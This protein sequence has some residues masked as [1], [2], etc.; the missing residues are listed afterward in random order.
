MPRYSA[1]SVGALLAVFASGAA[2]AQIENHAHHELHS[3]PVEDG[4]AV[5][6]DLG[7]T[8]DVWANFGGVKDGT[9]YLDNLDLIVGA[10]LEKLIGWR[11]ATASAYVLYNNGKSFG[12]LTGDALA[13]SNIE[14]GVQAVRLYEAWIE[15][16]IVSAATVKVGLYDL[17]SEFDSLE[18]A[19]LF[20]GSAHGIGMD[21]AQTGENGPSIFPSTSLA[22]RV[23]F[24]VQDNLVIR[25]AVLD[26]VPGNPDHPKRTAIRL[27]NGEGV[28]L[29]GEIDYGN[30]DARL[31]AGAWG[32]SEA[33]PD[34]TGAGTASSSGIYLRG[35]AA[36]ADLGQSKL[37]AFFRLGL[38]TGESNQ[39]DRFVSGGFTV[40]NSL[41]N[42]FGL[43][44]ALAAT[45]RPWRLANPGSGTHEAVFEATYAHLIRDFIEIQPNL[46]YVIK[47]SAD[48]LTP[49][50][51]AIGVRV[52]ISI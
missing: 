33:Q 12:E 7:Y 52:A 1:A 51:L 39:F 15:A 23:Q 20:I 19:S 27:G 40:E 2:N 5:T 17:N 21:I 43:A 42:R 26:A 44:G 36:M 28:L 25:A 10:D 4:D 9:R 11:G 29:I 49:D 38:A 30:E 6:V 41:G 31:L 24:A 14:T 3:M 50:A 47:P 16:P 13:V 22:A 18:T 48:G 35:E 46:Q 34:L 45:S 8:A 37:R 32:Y